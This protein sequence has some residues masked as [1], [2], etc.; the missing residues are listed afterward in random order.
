[1]TSVQE[2]AFETGVSKGAFYKH[3]A[4][5]EALLIELVKD[6]HNKM[7]RK[8]DSVQIGGAL[9]GKELL[10][11]RIE[12]ELEQ[13]RQNSS[14]FFTLFKE[15]PPGE[16]NEI[17][18]MMKEFHMK[19]IQWHKQSLIEAFGDSPAIW[20]I[21]VM[22]EGILKEYIYLLVFKQTQV[23]VDRLAHLLTDVLE[24]MINRAK[25]LQ[26]ILSEETVLPDKQTD[27][28]AILKQQLHKLLEAVRQE[29]E[30]LVVSD[31]TKNNTLAALNHLS[32]EIQKDKPQT[33]LLDALLHYLKRQDSIIGSI[34]QIEHTLNRLLREEGEDR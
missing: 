25:N 13:T 15:F 17:S 22:F 7:F 10:K 16:S 4:S 30:T 29:A 6:T 24:A 21:V 19:L 34:L 5:K 3:F 1:M 8:A 20:D 12:I 11:K 9:T 2:I 32:D 27:N 14:I 18:H 28:P 26:P 23:P 31:K 33:Y